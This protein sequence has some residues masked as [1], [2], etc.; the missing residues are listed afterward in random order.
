MRRQK[1]FEACART[2]DPEYS[3]KSSG[4]AGRTA[5]RPQAEP[6]LKQEKLED[7]DDSDAEP[8]N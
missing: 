2:R 6:D 4:R 3:L 5:N 1:S 8:E 7:G